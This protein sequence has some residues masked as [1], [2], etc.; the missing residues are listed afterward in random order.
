MVLFRVPLNRDPMMYFL[1]IKEVSKCL[2]MFQWKSII[3]LDSQLLPQMRKP[4]EFPPFH[5]EVWI[6]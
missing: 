2:K 3:N 5:L 4:L 1:G 6:T